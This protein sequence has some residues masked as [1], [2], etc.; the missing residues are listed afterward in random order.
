M[1]TKQDTDR[2]EWMEASGLKYI[3]QLFR[4]AVDPN[5][6]LLALVGIFVTIVIGSALDKIWVSAGWGVSANAIVA[7]MGVPSPDPAE[8]S[9]NEGVFQ[10]FRAFEIRAVRDAIESAR[11][12]TLIGPAYSHSPGAGGVSTSNYVFDYNGRGIFYNAVLMVRGVV[13]MFTAHPIYAIIFFALFILCWSY[14][15]GAI[16]RNTALQFARNERTSA[17]ESLRFTH[18]KA[19]GGFFAAP[20]IPMGMVGLIAIV[21]ILGGVFLSIPWLGDI[22]GGLAFFLALCGGLVI[23][24]LSVG[25]VG[26]GPLFWPTLAVEDSDA[27]DAVARSYSYLFARPLRLLW[28]LFLAI[29]YGSFCWLAIAFVAWLTAAATH[30]FVGIGSGFFGGGEDL[31]NK[32]SGLWIKPTFDS[33]V[34]LPPDLSGVSTVSAYLIGFWTLL[35]LGAVWAFLA[36]FF[37]SGSTV[38]YFL[39]RRDVDFVDI[40]EIYIDDSA[41]ASDAADASTKTDDQNG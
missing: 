20:I 25:F 1:S 35:L 34:Q 41:D 15:G 8:A 12:G 37:F 22:V 24:V 17:L 6:L 33:L 28:Y 32:L 29:V 10:V 11:H 39:M 2:T 19:L 18:R 5:K 21:L 27:F 14:A 31:P 36:S 13:W 23:A 9:S 26:G 7:S 40:G 38:I 3:L 16:C 30:L 4:I